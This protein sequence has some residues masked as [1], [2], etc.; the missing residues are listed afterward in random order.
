MRVES[1]YAEF[2]TLGLRGS[3]LHLFDH[4]VAASRRAGSRAGRDIRRIEALALGE[5][6]PQDARVLVGDGPQ[7]S[8]P[9]HACLELNDPAREP[10]GSS[11][12]AR[13]RGARALEQQRAQ[14]RVALFGDAAQAGLAAAALLFG[15]R[16]DPGGK[17]AAVLEQVS[18]ADGRHRGRGSERPDADDRHGALPVCVVLYMRA[19]LCVAP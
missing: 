15:H 14:I 7:R 2:P 1:L 4:A 11:M 6:C 8:I 5:N 9:T 13:Y 19:D 17:L 10:V 16:A 12:G 18:V 3:M